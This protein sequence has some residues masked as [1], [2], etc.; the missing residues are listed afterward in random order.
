MPVLV[1]AV[2]AHATLG[3]MSD[4]LRSVWGEH[5]EYITI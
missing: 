3:E 1:E 5:R 4:A 2:H